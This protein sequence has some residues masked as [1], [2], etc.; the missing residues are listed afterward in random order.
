MS[1]EAVDLVDKHPSCGDMA[2][3]FLVSH[4]SRKPPLKVVVIVICTS[5]LHTCTSLPARSQLSSLVP[6]LTS[7]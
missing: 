7:S 2:M 3:S 1:R 4:I 5:C 6:R